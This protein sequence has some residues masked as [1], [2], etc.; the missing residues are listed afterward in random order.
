METKGLVEERPPPSRESHDTKPSVLSAA[1]NFPGWQRL[2]DLGKV[3]IFPAVDSLSLI[4]DQVLGELSESRNIRAS[5][6]LEWDLLGYMKSQY[7]D[8]DNADLGSVITLSGTVLHAQATTCS[9]YAQ[10]TWPSQG[11]KV[12]EA[13]QIAIDVREHDTQGFFSPVLVGINACSN[14]LF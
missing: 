8:N 14:P 10:Q 13:F 3:C 9:A 4:R 5:L 2:G 11:L 12:I 1:S 6:T 7:P